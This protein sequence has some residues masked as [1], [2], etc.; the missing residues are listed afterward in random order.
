MSTQTRDVPKRA[1]TIRSRHAGKPVAV[2]RWGWWGTPVLLFPTAG[3]DAEECER[4]KMM[5]SL[6]PL[7][8]A[9]RIK[10]YSCDSLGGQE[11]TRKGRT[12]ATFAKAQNE[13]DRF[14]ADEMHAWIAADCEAKGPL[15][16]VTMGASIGAYNAAAAVCRHPDLFSKAICLSGTYDLTKW[17]EPPYST[18]YYFTSPMHFVVNLP[19]GPQLAA[20]RR[21]FILLATGSGPWEEPQQSW[22]LAHVLGSKNVPNRVDDW[23]KDYDHNWPTWREMAPKYL[24]ELA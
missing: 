15:E 13:F 16:V 8:E 17:L 5:V 24:S 22:R 20:L 11:L 23:G 7:L 18:E 10:V 21:R 2:R 12:T 14:L 1:D 19:E 9:G 6:R 3:G 4:M